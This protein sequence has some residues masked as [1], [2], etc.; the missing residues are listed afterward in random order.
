MNKP[1]FWEVNKHGY[2]L[3]GS[4]LG[5]CQPTTARVAGNVLRNRGYGILRTISFPHC[6]FRSFWSQPLDHQNN[7]SAIYWTSCIMQI[8]KYIYIVFLLLVELVCDSKHNPN[9][10]FAQKTVYKNRAIK[11]IHLVY[12]LIY[13][14]V[15]KER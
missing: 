10:E 4:R 6:F 5:V 13:Y 12:V 3:R 2:R 11:H 7:L 8:L 15:G 9:F 14:I 1:V